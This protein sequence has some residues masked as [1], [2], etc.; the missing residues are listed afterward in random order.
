LSW[1]VVQ[2][3][4]LPTTPAVGLGLNGLDGPHEPNELFAQLI[5]PIS[6]PSYF[7]ITPSSSAQ[8]QHQ[9]NTVPK[10]SSSTTSAY[11]TK[12]PGRRSKRTPAQSISST[13]TAG[14][15]SRRGVAADAASQNSASYLDEQ[16][17]ELDE[18]S[19]YVHLQRMQERHQVQQEPGWLRSQHSLLQAKHKVPGTGYDGGGR[20]SGAGSPF[21]T[22]GALNNSPSGSDYSS[23]PSFLPSLSRHGASGSASPVSNNAGN[24]LHRHQPVLAFNCFQPGNVIC[25]P[26]ERSLGG[27]IFHKTFVGKRCPLVATSVQELLFV[28]DN[29]TLFCHHRHSYL[30][31]IALLSWSIP[32]SG[33]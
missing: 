22:R 13:I 1:P 6:G 10:K 12:T 20:K 9:S 15:T 4:S 31:T 32:D 27:L 30:D 16:D 2:A 5:S 21:L 18:N 33:P 24:S 28:I 17:V 26:R 14:S 3:P 25:V 29:H 11:T 19:F 23:S 8:L 7:D